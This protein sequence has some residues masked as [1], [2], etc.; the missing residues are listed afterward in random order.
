MIVDVPYKDGDDKRFL[1]ALEGLIAI[2][3]KD[4][5]PEHV[6]VV[7]INKWFD[8]K[9]LKYSGK[10]TVKFPE[11][12]VDVARTGNLPFE[13]G[14][15]W[16]EFYNEKLTFPPFS[17][18]QIGAQ[19][20]WKR[21]ADGT[22]GGTKKPKWIYKPILQP[23]VLNLQNRVRAFANSG[24]F[25]WFSSNTVQNFQGSIMVYILTE[26]HELTWYASFKGEANWK[27]HRVK[28]IK[29]EMVQEW[30]PLG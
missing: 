3:V 27:V 12:G 21:R 13:H 24:V 20:H 1:T 10:G 28:G 22:Y 30:F 14:A 16:E 9:W 5:E 4:Y 6:Y 18:K 19:Y 25:I 7:R 8:H 15:A 26:N 2:I 23:S 17:P 11:R 29:K